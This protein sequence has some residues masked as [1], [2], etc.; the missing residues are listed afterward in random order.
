[1]TTVIEVFVYPL[2]WPTHIQWAAMMLVLL[3]R[4]AGALSLDAAM[5][6][7]LLH[8]NYWRSKAVIP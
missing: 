8:S 6:R 7:A 5:K 4:G 2:A 3:C 1:M